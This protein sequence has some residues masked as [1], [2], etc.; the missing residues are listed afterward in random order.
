[1]KILHI[2]DIHGKKS[3]IDKIGKTKIVNPGAFRE[4]N[5]C[6]IDIQDSEISI[7]LKKV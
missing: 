5:Y 3:I 7:N 1:M 6:F 2:T 4:E